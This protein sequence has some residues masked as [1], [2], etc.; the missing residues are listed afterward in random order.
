MRLTFHA[1]GSMV[2]SYGVT[3]RSSEYVDRDP[4]Y[5]PPHKALKDCI[6]YVCSRCGYSWDGAPA[7][8]ADAGDGSDSSEQRRWAVALLLEKTEKVGYAWHRAQIM[9][10]TV[11]S[12]SGRKKEAASAFVAEVME[13]PDAEG[14]SVKHVCAMKI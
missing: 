3:A 6:V 9:T 2:P 7:Q 11:D 5:L 10:M 14:F 8:I 1:A 4:Y 13:R 12:I